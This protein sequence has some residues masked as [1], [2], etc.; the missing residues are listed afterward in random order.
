MQ[1]LVRHQHASIVSDSESLLCLIC[2]WKPILRWKWN[3]RHAKLVSNVVT[4]VSRFANCCSLSVMKL[5]T[6]NSW[7]NRG[8]LF[9]KSW[10]LLIKLVFFEV[11]TD[12]LFGH[13]V[14][15]SSPK[16]LF[17]L[18]LLSARFQLLITD[19]LLYFTVLYESATSHLWS[20]PVLSRAWRQGYIR[21][22]PRL[23]VASSLAHFGVT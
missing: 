21:S 16:H 18:F 11:Q 7:L 1:L 17:R 14:L 5:L 3:V 15:E 13:M 20:V 8:F 12:N 6:L 19:D 9:A 22:L 2:F 4:L 23:T 10:Q